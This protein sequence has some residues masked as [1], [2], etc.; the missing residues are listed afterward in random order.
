MRYRLVISGLGALLC[1]CL[2]HPDLAVHSAR[3]T[4]V[5]EASQG[6]NKRPHHLLSLSDRRNKRHTPHRDRPIDL[7]AF[8]RILIWAWVVSTCL[9]TPFACHVVRIML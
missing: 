5:G 9:L 8:G 7:H 1:S 3:G 4:A 2:C 6:C